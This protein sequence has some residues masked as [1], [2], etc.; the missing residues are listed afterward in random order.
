M[1]FIWQRRSYGEN[2]LCKVCNYSLD[3]Q[4]V[5]TLSGH[6]Y[7]WTK[8]KVNAFN[9][10]LQCTWDNPYL[11]WFSFG[12]CFLFCWDSMVWLQ[13]GADGDCGDDYDVHDGSDGGGDRYTMT[14]S[15]IM[16][17]YILWWSVCLFVTKNEHFLKRSV[18]LFVM[19]YP[20]CLTNHSWLYYYIMIMINSK[21]GIWGTKRDVENTP[22]P[23]IDL[24][25]LYPGLTIQPRPA[26]RRAE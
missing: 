9:K 23:K 17:I 10:V 21:K 13:T 22:M 19:F 24:P 8:E 16:M 7:S 14:I 6:S 1:V 15:L 5:V 11:Q 26:A 2:G 4:Q 18:C 12:F 25:E 20:H 3:E